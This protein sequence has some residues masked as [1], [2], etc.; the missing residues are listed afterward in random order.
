[1][2][3]IGRNLIIEKVKDVKE[4]FDSFGIKNQL[5]PGCPYGLEVNAGLGDPKKYTNLENG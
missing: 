4:I 5:I 1:M 3:A 2:K